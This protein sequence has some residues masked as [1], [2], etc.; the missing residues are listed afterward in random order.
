MK[1]SIAPILALMVAL[2]FSAVAFAQT[3]APKPAAAPQ[4]KAEPAKTHT[5]KGTVVSVDALAN[6]LVVK[7]KKAEETFQVDPTAKIVINKKEVKLADLKKDTKVVVHYKVENG[8]KIATA[9]K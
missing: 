9:I 2:A 7:G 4:E 5:I 1:K 8:K 3:T 6:S